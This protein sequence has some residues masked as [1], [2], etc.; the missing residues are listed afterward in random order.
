MYLMQKANFF[1]LKATSNAHL[2]TMND[3]KSFKNITSL[4]GFAETIEKENKLYAVTI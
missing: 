4:R 2:R 1:L 3:A